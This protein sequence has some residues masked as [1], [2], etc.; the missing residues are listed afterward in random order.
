MGANNTEP[1]D[2][3]PN[4]DRTELPLQPGRYLLKVISSAL[5]FLQCRT[6]PGLRLERQRPARLIAG[7]F[8]FFISG[9]LSA[10]FA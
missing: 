2:Q 8:Q 4:R 7:F 1:V 5:D 9:T 3:R 6:V 10:V